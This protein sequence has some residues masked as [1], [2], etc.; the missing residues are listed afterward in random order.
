MKFKIT[1]SYNYYSIPGEDRVIAKFYC[2]NSIPFTFDELDKE[3]QETPRIIKLAD[4]NYRYTAEQIFKYSNYLI[5][6]EAHPLVFNL[7][8]DNPE[9]LPV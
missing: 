3:E 9:E 8:L 5:L 7:E 4:D 2:I 6:E 1:T